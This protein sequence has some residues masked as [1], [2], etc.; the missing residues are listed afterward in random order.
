[1]PI[2]PRNTQRVTFSL[3][4][5]YCGQVFVRSAYIN[6]YD[7]LRLFRFRTCKGVTASLAVTPEI[8][9]IDAAV[10][11]NCIIDEESEHFS[12]NKPGDDP[13]EVF[14][15]REYSP[16]DKLNRIHWK[17]S[18]KKDDFIVK[19]Y[20]LPI[21]APALIFV[22]LKCYEDSP[23]TLPVF[24]T[25][26]ETFASLSH[27]MISNERMHKLVYYNAVQG[28]FIQR[29]ITDFESLT[30]AVNEMITSFSD[31][32]Y[33]GD[34]TAYLAEKSFGTISSF[35]LVSS[36]KDGKTSAF[37]ADEIS[38]EIKN[39]LIIVPFADSRFTAPESGDNMKTIPVIAGHI[40]A[41]IKDIEL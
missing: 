5:Q 14:S 39:A 18:S 34:P 8:H 25:I 26:I 21:D 12:E 10:A 1:M 38:A 28:N 9:E 22:D 7:P 13:S 11:E 29:L 40:S 15:L 41:S 31:N 32:L 37:I 36:E 24:D 3:S 35:T 23:S 27:F 30:A 19:D 4:S 20:S 6:I 16:G 2:Q 17:L 33:S